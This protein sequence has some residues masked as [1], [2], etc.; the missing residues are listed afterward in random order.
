MEYVQTKYKRL[1][2]CSQLL[3]I[4]IELRQNTY[5]DIFIFLKNITSLMSLLKYVKIHVS[6]LS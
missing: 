2:F 6:P 5:F 3:V 4:L 1:K